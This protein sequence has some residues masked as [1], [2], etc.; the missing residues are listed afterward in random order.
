MTGGRK[1]IESLDFCK[2]PAPRICVADFAQAD[3]MTRVTG[4]T[5]MSSDRINELK[6]E[7]QIEYVR[8]HERHMRHIYS[9]RWGGMMLSALIIGIGALMIF[10]G[11]QGTFNWAIETPLSVSAKLT[12]ASPGIVFATIGLILGFVVVSR[13]PVTYQTISPDYSTM[14]GDPTSLLEADLQQARRKH[15][16]QKS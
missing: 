2:R 1:F 14:L 11:L 4:G 7:L 9:L 8:S 12:N 16:L 15:R 3:I 10:F 5:S 13:K 6:H